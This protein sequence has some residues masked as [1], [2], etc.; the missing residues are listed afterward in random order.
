MA[1]STS[2]INSLQGA[3]RDAYAAL[4]NL[5]DSYGLGSLS[6]TILDYLQQG[7]SADTITVLLQQSDA[8]QQRFA[9]NQVRIANGLSV[10]TPAE[11][12]STEASYQQLL[13]AAGLSDWTNK[14]QYSQ[15]IG[16][17]IS[18]TELQDR[19]SMASQAT[20]QASPYLKD[21]LGQLGLYG[22]D[23]TSY[24]LNTDTPTPKV[25]LKLAQAD[26]MAAAYQN[27]LQPSKKESK[28]YA[29]EGV[30]YQQAQAAY[31]KVAWA[32]PVAQQL[33]NIYGPFYDW[34]LD[35]SDLEH[36]YLGQSAFAQTAREELGREEQA[37]FSGSGGVG[38]NSFEQP[39]A[40]KSAF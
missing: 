21:A 31:Q 25:Q 28:I 27:N 18:P 22:T 24:F 8:Y 1:V 16:N 6:P 38:Q 7:F 34:T 36:E 29:Q 33:N 39:I 32:L 30:T 35:Q 20:I 3:Q 13:N 19:I 10:L 12:L 11:Y 37:T 40:G 23:I 5:F 26:I 4:S 15:W 9:G 2:V 14:D 17:D